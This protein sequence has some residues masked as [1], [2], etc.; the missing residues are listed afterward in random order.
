MKNSEIKNKMINDFIMK[1]FV[2]KFLSMRITFN[3]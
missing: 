1:I 3:Y 2:N